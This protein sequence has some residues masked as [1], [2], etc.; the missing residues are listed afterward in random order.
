MQMAAL[1]QPWQSKLV[2]S[3]LL[4]VPFLAGYSP[5]PFWSRIGSCRPPRW[6]VKYARRIS[7][8]LC[9]EFCFLLIYFGYHRWKQT[10]VKTVCKYSNQFKQQFKRKTHKRKM[11]K[12]FNRISHWNNQSNRKK[13]KNCSSGGTLG[14]SAARPRVKQ[15]PPVLPPASCTHACSSYEKLDYRISWSL[16][17]Q[18]S[19][20]RELG[21]QSARQGVL[22][23]SV[24]WVP[25]L[26]WM[27]LAGDNWV[28]C[29]CRSGGSKCVGHFSRLVYLKD[30]CKLPVHWKGLRTCFQNTWMIHKTLCPWEASRWPGYR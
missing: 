22:L 10:R 16:F 15:I 19:H 23:H 25:V 26:F 13:S 12:Q 24:G 18:H 3:P 30:K 5:K 28:R 27:G 6:R 20:I 1:W 29:K 8:E 21:S 2:L 11:A 4:T 9:S 7:V 17:R 14:T